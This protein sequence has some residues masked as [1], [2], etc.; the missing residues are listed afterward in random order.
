MFHNIDIVF[1]SS[2]MFHSRPGG[3]PCGEARARA[4]PLAKIFLKF[5]Q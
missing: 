1:H 4:K 5:S 2:L 3:G